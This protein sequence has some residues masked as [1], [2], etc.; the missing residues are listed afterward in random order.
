MSSRSKA[1]SDPVAE[2]ATDTT[3]RELLG[4]PPLLEGENAADSEALY[5]RVS[6]TVRSHDAIEAI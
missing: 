3:V 5:D 4:E 1:L 2:M 6:A